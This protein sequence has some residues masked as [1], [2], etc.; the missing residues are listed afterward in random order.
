MLGGIRRSILAEAL[1]NYGKMC[2]FLLNELMN[3][4]RTMTTTIMIINIW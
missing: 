1:S 3:A 2:S 4:R